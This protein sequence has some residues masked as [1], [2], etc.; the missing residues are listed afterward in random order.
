MMVVL[1]A[2]TS[3]QVQGGTYYGP[4]KLSETRGYPAAAKVPAQAL[5]LGTAERLW[6]ESER[7]TGALFPP[8]R[9]Q[10]PGV[11]DIRK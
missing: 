2:A 10:A 5:D 7:L 6:C 1:F 11:A 4:D 9:T 8:V 3:P